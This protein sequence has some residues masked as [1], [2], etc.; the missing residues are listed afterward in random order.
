MCL[1]LSVLLFMYE[2]CSCLCLLILYYRYEFSVNCSKGEKIYRNTEMKLWTCESKLWCNAWIHVHFQ[3]GYG[4]SAFC[5]ILQG[6]V[7]NGVV[8]D[9]GRIEIQTAIDSSLYEQIVSQVHTLI[10]MPLT[11]A[12]NIRQIGCFSFHLTGQLLM[13]SVND[14]EYVW[15]EQWE[16]T[17]GACQQEHQGHEHLNPI[18]CLL[19]SETMSSQKTNE[20]TTRK[21]DVDILC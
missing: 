20:I 4:I 5:L 3:R 12:T 2:F 21:N 1:F 14:I 19:P 11:Q 8:I 13:I 7:L 6:E 18:C 15:H 10:K 17:P 16:C 9:H